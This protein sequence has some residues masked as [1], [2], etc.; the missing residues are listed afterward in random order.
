MYYILEKVIITVNSITIIII[1]II[2]I[3]TTTV[4]ASVNGLPDIQTRDFGP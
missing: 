1:S 4:I 2:I 3:K